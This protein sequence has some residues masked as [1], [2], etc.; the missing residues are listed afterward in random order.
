MSTLR[1]NTI[2]NTS[3]VNLLPSGN[4]VQTGYAR[5]DPNG[6][7]YTTVAQDV[8]LNSD[9]SLTFTPKFASSKLWILTSYHARIIAANGCSY[10]ILRDGV[11]LDGMV[12]RNGMDFFFKGDG[13]NH[14]YTGRCMTYINANSTSATTF[15]IWGQGWGGG[16]WER[17]YGHGEHSITVMEIAQ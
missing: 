4:V 3:S 6:D 12:N 17:S 11:E 10:G 8:R 15:T 2:Q 1:V 14:H 7:T 13:V 5:Y 9:V 16:I